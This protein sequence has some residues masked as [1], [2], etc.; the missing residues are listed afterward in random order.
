MTELENEP[1]RC[2]SASIEGLGIATFA[3][4]PVEIAERKT[5]VFIGSVCTSACQAYEA[6]DARAGQQRLADRNDG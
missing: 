5:F 4:K 1:R 2:V 6:C 3:V